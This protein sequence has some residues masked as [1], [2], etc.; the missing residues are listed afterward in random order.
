MRMA[1]IGT[2]YW[3][4]NLVRVACEILGPEQ[5]TVFDVNAESLRTI[6]DQHPGI[7]VAP[8]YGSVL[9]DRMIEIVSLA[10]PVSTHVTLAKEALCAGKHIF[11]E[12]PLALKSSEAE[13]VAKLADEMGRIVMVGHILL[14]QPAIG[15]IKSA[16]GAGVI[17]ELVSLHQERLNFGIVRT[18]ENV[19]WSLGIH[20]IAVL[21]NL[22][23]QSPQKVI[24]Q[25]QAI[26]Q[27]KIQDD[28]YV[29]LLFSGGVRAH[30]HT[31]WL[32]PEKHRRL[33]IVGSR[34][35][36]TY[37]EGRQIV[38]LHRKR[39]GNDLM[40][41]DEGD[42]VVFHGSGQPLTLEIEHFLECIRYGR[43]PLSDVRSA[44][45]VVRVI[46]QAVWQ[47]EEA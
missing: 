5:V 10:T 30:L 32:W 6:A 28:V 23:G 33:T 22:V 31:S 19:L 11:V 44:V 9:N 45:D 1:V 20:D 3:G 7:S 37:D 38:M 29:H 43:Q 13:E 18:V 26:L 24:A 17:G 14:F 2:G 34:G 36:L 39:F 40:S 16:I 25:G 12:K 4:K 8:S 42:E 15:W 46:E 27:T 41:V 21:L 35:M 47:M